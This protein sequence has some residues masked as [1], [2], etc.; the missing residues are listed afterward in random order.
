MRAKSS[1]IMCPVIPNNRTAF[2]MSLLTMANKFSLK[3]K[4]RIE[5]SNITG[6]RKVKIYRVG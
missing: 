5:Y 1:V 2:S 4:N 3:L 6:R